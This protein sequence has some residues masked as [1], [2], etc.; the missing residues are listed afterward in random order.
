MVGALYL[1][2]FDPDTSVR[3]TANKTTAGLPDRILASALRDEGV[4]PVVLGFLLRSLWEKETYAEMLILNGSTPDEDIASIAAGCSAKSA[5]LISQN[6][7]RI[8]R[9]AEIIRRLC[10]NPNASRAL[11]DG[12]CDFA[13]R[14]GLD[15]PDVEQMKEARIRLFGP[16][17]AEKP[18]EQ[19]PTADQV[20]QEF[21]ELA[22]EGGAP[23]E[24]GKRLTLTQRVM[25]MSISEKIKLATRGNKEA[26]G[27]LLRDSNKLVAVA[28]IR[29][30][31]ITDGEVL[32]C[33]ANRAC[34]DD[35][36]RVIYNNRDWT[37]AYPIKLALVKNPRT[38]M[39][40]SMRFLNTLRESDVKDIS[41]DR[42]VPS[43]V[44]SLAKK[45]LEKKS[46]SK[47]E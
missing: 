14:S 4:Q 35:V 18:I 8:L 5:E 28:A 40:M 37:R 11:L 29:S 39:M 46:T 25:R 47:K 16:E 10:G 24:E 31:R 27:M 23:L 26:R 43:G 36:L 6:Q 15:L 3:D 9:H 1:L 19:G 17:A 34:Q 12:V 2:T 13:V 7:L 41:R 21:V 22:D 38:P 44:A 33:A 30:P 32:M 20:M 42:N 45:M